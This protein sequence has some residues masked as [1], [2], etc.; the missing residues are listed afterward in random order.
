MKFTHVI[1]LDMSK[2]TFNLF[3]HGQSFEREF[4]NTA[5]S[6]RKMLKTISKVLNTP[7]DQCLFC[8]EHTGLYSLEMMKQLSAHQ[9]RYAAISGLELN[10]SLGIRR[11]KSDRIDARR[12]AEYAFLRQEKLKLH[13]LP[14]EELMRLQD[15]LSLRALHVRTRA[16]YKA[17]LHEQKRVLKQMDNPILFQSQNRTIVYLSKEIKKV[18]QQILQLINESKPIKYYFDLICTITGIGMVVA[19]KVIVKTRCFA[20]FTDPRKFSCYIGSAPFPKESGKMKTNHRISHIADKEMKT[21]LTL[22]AQVAILYDPEIR[23]FYHRKLKDGKSKKCVRNAVRNK[24]IAR[25]F[26][27]AKRGTPYVVLNKFAA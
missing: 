17:R 2:E 22:A 3:V 26:S 9:I 13:E 25:I 1:G 11:G 21:L 19:A 14:S 8:L 12:I 7:I 6:I 15:L 5:N 23:D 4:R 10:R 24:L 27:V 16:G 18:E 20:S